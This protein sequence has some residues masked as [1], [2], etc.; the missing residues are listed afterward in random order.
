MLHAYLHYVPNMCPQYEINPLKT[1]GN[2]DYTN[3][4][5]IVQTAAK[6]LSSKGHNS[7]KF[8]FNFIKTYHA[9]LQY[10]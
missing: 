8:N 7:V 4:I 9:H 5:P 10:A 3:S 2:I 6:K 1:I